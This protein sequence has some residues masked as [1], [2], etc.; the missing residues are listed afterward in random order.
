M[1]YDTV[2]TNQSFNV[3]IEGIVEDNNEISDYWV[4]SGVIISEDGYILTAK[5][6]VEGS[7]YIKVTLPNREE[8]IITDFYL[9][10]EYDFAIIKLPIEVT[11]YAVL[12][13]SN[14]LSKGNIIYNIGNAGGIWRDKVTFGTVYDN[15]FKRIILDDL[16]YVFSKMK[17]AGGCSGGGVYRYNKLIG[18]VSLGGYNSCWIVPINE[19]KRD[20]TWYK[21]LME[22]LTKPTP[23]KG[24]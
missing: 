20:F 2:K 1:Y 4:G 10:E 17:V 7:D 12:G 18:V 8:F 22:V 14:D 19:I 21:N 3:L 16:E 11:Q 6:C 24:S 15:H 9:D 23:E 5:H 13:D